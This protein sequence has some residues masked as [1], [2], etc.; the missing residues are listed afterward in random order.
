MFTWSLHTVHK[1]EL[2]RKVWASL[3]TLRAAEWQKIDI[4]N[5]NKCSVH[6]KLRSHFLA[7]KTNLIGVHYL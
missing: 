6:C 2:E 5:H 4:L 7:I 1:E 3:L